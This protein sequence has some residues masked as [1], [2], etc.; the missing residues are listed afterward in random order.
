MANSTDLCLGC[1]KLFKATGYWSHLTQTRN[2]A[3]RAVYEEQLMVVCSDSDG[4][5]TSLPPVLETDTRSTPIPFM[6]D[7]FGSA[8]EYSNDDF[9]QIGGDGHNIQEDDNE[10]NE[11]GYNEGKE[12]TLERRMN[13]EMETSW[14][15]QRSNTNQSHGASE[16]DATTEED[17]E[18]NDPAFD[19]G[20]R[21]SAEGR[22]GKGSARIVRYSSQYPHSRAGAVVSTGQSTDAQYSSTLGSGNNLWAPFSSEVDWK[23]ARWAKLRGPGSTA[24]SELLAID[25]VSEGRL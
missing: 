14:E 4:D 18:D 17:N 22:A 1:G 11:E 10:N 25:G 23:V 16:M 9:G 21:L 13:Y 24:F 3:C 12:D 8:A 5:S 2:P 6:G 20:P 7:F 15:R 19:A